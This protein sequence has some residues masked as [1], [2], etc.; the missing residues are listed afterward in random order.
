[1]EEIQVVVEEKEITVEKGIT[2]YDLVKRS[3]EKDRVLVAKVNG[4]MREL[5]QTVDAPCEIEYLT[6]DDTEGRRTYVRGLIMMMLRAFY[7]EVPSDQ[8]DNITVHYALDNG[9]YCTVSGGMRITEAK[10]EKIAKRMRSYVEADERFEKKSVDVADGIQ[11]FEERGMFAKSKL[12]KYRRVSNVNLYS[13]GKVVDYFYGEMPYSTGVLKKFDLVK[14]DKGFVLVLPQRKKK[15]YRMDYHPSHKLHRELKRS[16]EWIDTLKVAN[17]GDL[18]DVIC[19]GSLRQLMLVQ[20]ALQEKRIG[21]LADRVVKNPKTRLV[22]IAGPSSSGKTTFSYR[23]SAQLATL[24]KRPHPIAMDDYFVNRVDTPRDEEGNYDYENISALD[25]ALFN[26]HLQRLLSGDEVQL[27]TY[28]FITGK[29]QYDKPPIRI[30]EDEILIVE[31]IHGL[32]E[33]LTSKIPKDQ[34]FKIYISALTALNIDEHNYISTS[35][36]RLLR[37]IVRDARTRGH[38]AA[39]S[40]SMWEAVRR[41]EKKNIFPYQEE[42]DAM[43]NSS[44]IYEAAALKTYVEPLLFAVERGTKEYS[45]AQKLLKFLDY[46]LS[47]DSTEVPLNSILREFI[48][49]GIL[50]N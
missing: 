14:Y 49:G 2:L 27:P 36:S 12:L 11:Y 31:G 8:F 22:T 20:E 45:V 47:I 26:E 33:K 4:V 38:S 24:G 29:R 37:R 10:L 34:K 46:F 44:I 48:G 21:D 28:N 39:H 42:A 1:M 6:Y 19:H 32:N 30:G 43:F 17:V 23:L 5:T 35:D 3:G 16:E 15:N 50:L 7:K 18:N 25:T 40:I 13:L 9:Y 41:G